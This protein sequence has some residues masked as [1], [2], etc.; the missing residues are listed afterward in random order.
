[1]VIRVLCNQKCVFKDFKLYRR[2]RIGDR[3]GGICVYVRNN[4]YS[5]GRN[6]L[7]LPDIE[8]IWIE[9]KLMIQNN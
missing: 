2:N 7:E 1:M 8:C 9:V 4:I 5:R 6:D 3:H